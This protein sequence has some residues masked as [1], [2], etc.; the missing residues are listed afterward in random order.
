[1]VIEERTIL[2]HADVA[3]GSRPGG[4]HPGDSAAASDIN[5]RRIDADH[6]GI[7]FDETTTARRRRFHLPLRCEG[8]RGLQ[9]VGRQHGHSRSPANS[10][11]LHTEGLQQLSF[12]DGDAA[13]SQA[14]RVE[15]SRLERVDDPAR[16]LH[17]EAQRDLGNDAAELAGSFLAPSLRSRRP[18]SRATARCSR[19][20]ED[21]LA[22]VTGFA[23]VSL[24]PNAG[25]QGEYA[26]LLAIRRYHHSRG[27]SHRNICLI[28]VSAHGTNP[29][30]AV[31]VGMK[32]VG[33]KCDD[34]REHRR[35]RSCGPHR[36]APRESGGLM[37]TYPSTHGVF[38]ETIRSRS[39]RSSTRRAARFT[40][41]A[42]T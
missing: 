6:L 16:L 33:V 12:R 18:E 23:G 37:V 3:Q 26:G 5:L 13:L 34:R 25:S 2:R 28:P 30:S 19:L 27:D 42:R 21:W 14:P 1:M 17:D 41:T 35:R 38:E 36:G 24:Q 7:S 29:A 15:G 39:A 11:F 20:L 31:M 4:C 40:W 32:V 10:A 22:E 9:Q 8:R